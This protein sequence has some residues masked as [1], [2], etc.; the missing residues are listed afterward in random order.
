LP[1]VLAAN[2]VGVIEGA[3]LKKTLYI[4]FIILFIAGGTVK[5]AF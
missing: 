3:E 4:I 2:A 5:K 1:C